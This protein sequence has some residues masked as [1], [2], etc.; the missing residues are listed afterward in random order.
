MSVEKRFHPMSITGMLL[1]AVVKSQRKRAFENSSDTQYQNIEFLTFLLD[2][3]QLGFK[4][5]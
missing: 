2:L 5:L 3:H 1:M 4:Q